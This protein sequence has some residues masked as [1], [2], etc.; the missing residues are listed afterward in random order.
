M[1]R[2]DAS[3]SA[4]VL[5]A[6]VARSARSQWTSAKASRA[7]TAAFVSPGLAGFAACAPK[8]SPVPIAGSTSTNALRSLAWEGPPA[9]ME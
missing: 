7:T 5:A 8:D 9:R 2:R 1:R 6:G 4:G 3:R